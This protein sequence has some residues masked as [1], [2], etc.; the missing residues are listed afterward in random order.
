MNTNIN[1]LTTTDCLRSNY[2]VFL[3]VVHSM[4]QSRVLTHCASL[5]DSSFKAIAN[6]QNKCQDARTILSVLCNFFW[7]NVY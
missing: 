1:S 7:D 6:T 4:F 5:I 2:M 3:G